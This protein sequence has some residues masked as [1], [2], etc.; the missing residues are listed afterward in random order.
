MFEINLGSFLQTNYFLRN[1]DDFYAHLQN[2][3]QKQPSNSLCLSLCM[4]YSNSHKVDFNGVS[5][6]WQY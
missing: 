1:E 3:C 6:L 5:N 2:S 4:Y